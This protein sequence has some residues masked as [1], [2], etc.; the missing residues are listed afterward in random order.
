MAR[1]R[2]ADASGQ[3][4]LPALA[5]LHTL[6]VHCT[7]PAD[8][9]LV[10]GSGAGSR[11]ASVSELAAAVGASRT[12]TYELLGLCRHAGL[13]IR[14]DGG[15]WRV[16]DPAGWEGQPGAGNQL[17]TW[18]LADREAIQ[19]LRAADASG[20]VWR[21]ALGAWVVL[22]H[23]ARW[24][25]GELGLDDA[26]A[27]RDLGI[28]QRTWARWRGLAEQAGLLTTTATGVAIHPWA[29]LEGLTPDGTPLP[30]SCSEFADGGV[31]SLQAAPVVPAR[32]APG[33]TQER[34]DQ[35]ALPHTRAE[36]SAPDSGSYPRE[37]G[38]QPPP[39]T[40]QAAHTQPFEADTSST[41][42]LADQ[43]VAAVLRHVQ[44]DVRTTPPSLHGPARAMLRRALHSLL[45]AD[46]D[47]T[48]RDIVE[49]ID[50]QG[51][52]LRTLREGSNV[53]AVVLARV[54]N[55]ADQTP[56][57]RRRREQR[58]VAAQ[59]A[60]EREAAERAYHAD[61]E[62]TAA[63]QAELEALPAEVQAGIYQQARQQLDAEQSDPAIAA[64]QA[65]L[66]HHA[67]RVYRRHYTA[68]GNSD[69]EVALA[70]TRHGSG[71]SAGDACVE[72]LGE[73]NPE[74][75]TATKAEPDRGNTQP[76]TMAARS[77]TG[78]DPGRSADPHRRDDNRV[79]EI[80]QR[81]RGCV[82][83][84]RGGANESRAAAGTKPDHANSLEAAVRW[85]RREADSPMPV[86]HLVDAFRSRGPDAVRAALHACA[87]H[88][89]S[90]QRARQAR[91]L[92]ATTR[93]VGGGVT[94]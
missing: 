59:K 15:R 11:P 57:R 26:Q 54:R 65:L 12:T 63:V 21:S 14:D 53:R 31:Q 49:A 75:D 88:T 78:A 61:R 69:G 87:D 13:L 94:G 62:A 74:G 37:E 23:R 60:A 81:T 28:D 7:R 51:P 80:G 71:R 46:G 38:S 72:R 58:A 29:R 10:S 86:E 91:R 30:P 47:W 17:H 90:P 34:G 20:R 70:T 32:E 45:Q 36:R 93:T 19:A 41:D 43:A 82:P 92:A 5:L 18:R 83:A 66:R 3:R 68:G 1:L 56:P 73:P 39:D 24:D 44:A 6:R 4:W 85:G 48:P 35:Q 40:T 25:T 9:A 2:L 8:G 27:G 52:P 55:L 50:Q 33:V 89:S 84:E 79:R 64:S 22:R 16:A 67:R 76:D 77:G 42:E